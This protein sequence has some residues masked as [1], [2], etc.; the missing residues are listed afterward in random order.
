MQTDGAIESYER[1]LKAAKAA[2]ELDA[3]GAASQQI[4][5][6]YQAQVRPTGSTLAFPAPVVVLNASRNTAPA[7]TSMAQAL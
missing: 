2:K 7:E 5:R 1:C 4:A 6:L 3:A